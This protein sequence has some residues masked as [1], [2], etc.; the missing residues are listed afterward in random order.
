MIRVLIAD[1][2]ASFRAALAFMLELEEDLIVVGQA[3]SLTEARTILATAPLD[4]ALIDL[5]FPDG[6]GLDLLPA[7]RTCN[8]EAAT[9]ILSGSVRPESAPLAVAAGAAGFLPKLASIEAIVT[10]IRRVAGGEMLFTAGE[11]VALMREAEQYQARTRETQQALG[12]LTPRELD[13]L[14]ALAIGLDNQAIARRLFLSG[15][16]TRT[17]VGSVLRKLGVSSRLQAALLAVR[18]GFVDLD[19]LL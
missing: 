19:D 3:G 15:G 17:H 10:A 2:H 18:H 1:D 12:N 14:R 6:H 16:T 4:V 8:P 9:V 13:V 11:A 7:I 5:E